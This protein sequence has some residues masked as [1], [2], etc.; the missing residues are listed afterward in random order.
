MFWA[1]FSPLGPLPSASM[2]EMKPCTAPLGAVVELCSC[3]L[4]WLYLDPAVHRVLWM[5]VTWVL[6]PLPP[7]LLS[8]SAPKLLEIL[9]AG[10]CWVPPSPVHSSGTHRGTC[11]SLI[12]SL[13]PSHFTSRPAPDLPVVY[14]HAASRHTQL[15]SVFLFQEPKHHQHENR[16]T[17]APHSNGTE[18]ST[19]TRKPQE[20]HC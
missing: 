5:T 17:A 6:C 3:A 7:L 8:A 9:K 12:M 13:S 11:L 19:E 4:C 20:Q 16:D 1:L 10:P 18:S 14:A 2:L 15:H